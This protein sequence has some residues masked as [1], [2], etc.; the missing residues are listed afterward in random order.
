MLVLANIVE[1]LEQTL[2]NYYKV[3]SFLFK[4]D[5]GYGKESGTFKYY[6]G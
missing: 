6:C 3:C 1:I 5:I 2:Y 4:E